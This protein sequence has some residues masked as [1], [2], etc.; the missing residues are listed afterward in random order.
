MVYPFIHVVALLRPVG[1]FPVCWDGPVVGGREE[2]QG[3][4][5]E[6]GVRTLSNS[7]CH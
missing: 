1:G 5:E 3:Q 6:Q 4:R 7:I 2:E